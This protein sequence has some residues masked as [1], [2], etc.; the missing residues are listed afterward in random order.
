MPRLRELTREEMLKGFII[1]LC[2]SK[3]SVLI[4]NFYSHG[5]KYF[6]ETKYYRLDEETK[7][8]LNNFDPYILNGEQIKNGY[9]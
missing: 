9:R 7:K 2:K 3:K 5:G 1:E 4:H 8:M 6:K